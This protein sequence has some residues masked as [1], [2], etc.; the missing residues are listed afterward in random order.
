M[1]EVIFTTEGPLG[2]ITL[3]R[4]QALNALNLAMIQ[5]IKSQLKHWGKSTDIKAVLVRSHSERAFCAG[6]DIRA[7]YEYKQQGRN[8][9][10]NFFQEE[11]SLNEMIKNYPKPYIALMHGITMGGGLGISIHGSLRI[12]A[13]NLTLAMPETGIGFFPDVG[14]SY[15][16]SRAP[17]ETG[18][19]IGLTSAR[20]EVSDAY[21]AKLIDK[22]IDHRQLDKVFNQLQQNITTD[23]HSNT[24]PSSKLASHRK[25][26]DECFSANSV[27]EIVAR[28]QSTSHPWADETRNALQTKS[29]TSLK[30]TLKALRLAT[31]LNFHQCM[32]ME[33]GIAT[34]FLKNHDFFEGI[35]AVLI[36]KDQKPAW[37]PNTLEQVDKSIVDR[38]FSASH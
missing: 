30:V 28:L 18:T 34:E 16:L 25:L 17:G 5:G 19:Y 29:P 6:G 11:Y 24:P 20:L 23:I 8:D 9:I 3:N 36:D 10:A 35:R 26:I 13:D 12:A 4:P 38:Y 2:V 21:Y 32:Q 14:G 15:F 1:N 37:Q 27:E 7:V 22:V 31:T 33:F